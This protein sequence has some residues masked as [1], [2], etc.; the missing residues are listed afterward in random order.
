MSLTKLVGKLKGKSAYFIRKE[1]WAQV[2]NKLWGK[3]FWSPSYCAVSG[4]DAPLEI[5]KKKRSG[6]IHSLNKSLVNDRK[7]AH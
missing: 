7:A 2:K 4:G 6:D 1:H 5:I 3:H